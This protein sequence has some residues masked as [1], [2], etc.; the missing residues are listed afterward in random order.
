VKFG[1]VLTNLAGGGTEKAVLKLAHALAARGNEVHLLLLEHLIAHAVPA[2]ARVHALTRPGQRSSKGYLGRRLAA[3]RLRGL[4]RKL[5]RRSPFDLVV[6]TLPF[7]DEVAVLAGAPRQWCRIANTLS[8]EIEHLRATDPRKAARRLARYRR[9]YTGRPL[10]AVSDGVASDLRGALGLEHARIE[11]IYNPFDFA[12]IRDRAAAPARLP[13]EPYVIH[14]GRFAAQKRHDLLLDAW[15]AIANP[16]LL[17]LLCAPDER[18]TRMIEERGL[19]RRVTVAGFQAN[20]YPWIA[21]AE[22]L[23]LSS[24]HEGLPNVIVEALAVGT[25]VVSTD[26]P[27]GPREILGDVLCD[28]L[29]PTGDPAALAQAVARALAA[30]P[31][32]S[33]ADLTP[34]GA[35][36]V[37]AAYERIAVERAG[38]NAD[39]HATV[40]LQQP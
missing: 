12:D 19:G 4:I 11:R 5:E 2:D 32:A 37:A 38:G 21:N 29:V 28:Y 20:P 8:A 10:I 25:P 3:W 39:A 9:L 33:R 23:V 14:V 1:F 35:E 17:V 7:A 30:P 24:D 27:S 26:C 15:M 34:Y 36:T 22:L 16:P 6:S 40:G 13:G 31:D 18:L